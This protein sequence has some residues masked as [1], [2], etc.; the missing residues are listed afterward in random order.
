MKKFCF[1]AFVLSVLLLAGCK[2]GGGEPVVPA[3][4]TDAPA[5]TTVEVTT[6]VAET[7]PPVVVEIS[8][9]RMDEIYGKMKY[10]KTISPDLYGWITIEGTDVDY[11][12]VQAEDNDFYLDHAEDKQW[13][14]I[15][16]IFADFRN[17]KTVEDPYNYNIVTYGHNLSWGGM[18]HAV[19]TIFENEQ[20]F[21]DTY[22]YL[23][24]FDGIYVYEPFAVYEA[25]A[26]YQYFRTHFDTPE[27]FVAFANEMKGNS[28]Y[29]E[30]VE[31]DG[32]D[33]MM[34]LSTCT[35]TY[36]DGRY[37]LQAKR[38]QVTRWK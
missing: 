31:F 33:C 13:R 10:Y 21:R 18:Y 19:Q 3:V 5:V 38:V 26:Y 14:E 8:K 37:A 36:A 20:L 34:T 1:T 7:E 9:E 29:A 30:D 16:S 35:N 22:I 32:N 24:T 28:V 2:E 23:Y 27:E 25:N 11:P 12:V 4:T 15:G 6:T 17:R